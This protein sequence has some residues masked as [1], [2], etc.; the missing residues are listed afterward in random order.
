MKLKLML[1]LLCAFVVFPGC[2]MK[3]SKPYA[4]GGYLL[5]IPEG[6]EVEK[7]G[8]DGVDMMATYVEEVEPIVLQTVNVVVEHFP[9]LYSEEKYL[10]LNLEELRKEFTVSPDRKF[11]P[12]K[13]GPYSGYR[14]EYE[15]F[16]E[17]V[18]LVADLY[19][20]IH[21]D[22]VYA[23]TCGTFKGGEAGFAPKKKAILGSFSIK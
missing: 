6:W 23:I 21:D 14:L 20:V 22:L 1:M 8:G 2:G 17:G 4:G 13:V 16:V 5:T 9:V 10:A 18:P 3:P 19:I 12:A 15:I 11:V 7:N